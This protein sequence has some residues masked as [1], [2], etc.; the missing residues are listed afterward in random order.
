MSNWTPLEL[1]VLAGLYVQNEQSFLVRRCVHRFL[2]GE[3]TAREAIERIREHSDVRDDEP[4]PEA[5]SP[6]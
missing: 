4:A 5:P 6:P 1:R 3:I 2:A